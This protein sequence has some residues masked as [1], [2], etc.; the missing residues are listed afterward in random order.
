MAQGQLEVSARRTLNGVRL[1]GEPHEL[2]NIAICHCGRERG[3]LYVLVQAEGPRS[4]EVESIVLD[5]ITDFYKQASGSSV[6]GALMG[7]IKEANT[8][9]F[10]DNKVSMRN[11]QTRAGVYCAVMRPGQ[12]VVLAYAGPSVAL[13]ITDDATTHLPSGSERVD[14]VTGRR[15]PSQTTPL[16][17]N[18]EI[19]PFLFKSPFL[20][21]DILVLATPSLLSSGIDDEE[22]TNALHEEG[23]DGLS[24]SGDGAMLVLSNP[25]SFGTAPPAAPPPAPEDTSASKAA[26]LV[27][28][29]T[30]LLRPKAHAQSEPAEEPI[31]AED[32]PELVA[33]VAPAPQ[34]TPKPAPV[35]AATAP[36]TPLPDW[37]DDKSKSSRRF[38]R[39]RTTNA[40]AGR[41]LSLPHSSRWLVMVG[42]ALAVV[43]L[44]AAVLWWQGKQQAQARENQYQSLLS[45][46]ES[47][48]TLGQASFDSSQALKNLTEAQALVDQALLVK[49]EGAEALALRDGIVRDMDEAKGVTH[50]D[51][52]QVTTLYTFGAAGSNPTRLIGDGSNL[53]V[54]DKGE[55][56]VYKFALNAQGNALQQG[57]DS[58]LLRKG[59]QVGGTVVGDLVDIAWIPEG[60]SRRT[61]N[62]VALESGGNL[63]QYD[64]A[65]G[66][67]VLP[68]KD[69]NTIR[70]VQSTGGY[71]GNFYVLDSVANSTKRWRPQG[72]GYEGAPQEYLQTN[73]ELI[74]AVDMA[75]DGDI[76]A[77][78]V[79]GQIVWLSN[80]RPQPFPIEGLDK[81]MAAPVSI[82]T[83]SGTDAIYVA[84]PTNARIVKLG[85]QG[86]VQ[87]QLVFNEGSGS[88]ERLRGVFADDNKK[89]IYATAG[90]QL[91]QIAQP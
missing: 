39:G 28:T 42:A 57:G 85:K 79:N 46:A 52:S 75:I 22:L 3:S 60:G 73:V 89:S 55:Q 29:L 77:L 40:G 9:L 16:G 4:A 78:L 1:E 67:S 10:D 76:F 7:A 45:Q 50:L 69:I 11:Q 23:V 51:P 49:P 8:V 13:L 21:G 31:E 91:L 5:A 38:D 6:T 70:K 86:A 54:L 34:P 83:N 48:R 44:V 15:T 63:I 82:F 47:A 62:L 87:R 26:S 35:S 24:T 58:V 66:L 90:T 30:A 36:T 14:M 41:R 56:K 80:G 20:P 19:D 2:G 43:L 17:A 71:G 88:F 12:D 53:Y 72:K 25:D 18:P 84:D 65:K 33:P 81:P 32:Q 68:V 61:A 37:L 27:T 59:D 74:N 64:A